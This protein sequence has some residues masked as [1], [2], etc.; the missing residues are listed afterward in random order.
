MIGGTTLGDV[1]RA[2]GCNKST[3]SR[4]LRGLSGVQSATAQKIRTVARELGYQPD[5]IQ[6]NAAAHRWRHSGRLASYSVAFL[7]SEISDQV[8]APKAWQRRLRE[9]AGAAQQRLEAAGCYFEIVNICDYRSASSL[10]RVLQNRG[11]RGVIVPPLPQEARRFMESFDWESFA[12]VALKTGWALPPCHS[13]DVDEWLGIHGAW[14]ELRLRG[15]SRI[16]LAPARHE[17]RALDDF[18]R[19]GA[20]AALSE[21]GMTGESLP[22]Y[23]GL[24]EDRE[25]FLRWLQ[26]VE[27][28][29]VIGFCNPMLDW[30]RS[31]RAGSRHEIGFASLHVN[32]CTSISGMVPDNAGI[33][34]AAVD[35]LMTEIR[36]NHWG[37]PGRRQ[38]ILLAPLWNEGLTLRERLPGPSNID[39]GPVFSQIPAAARDREAT[40]KPP[41]SPVRE[42]QGRPAAAVAPPIPAART[43]RG[44]ARR[45]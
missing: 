19:H 30:L 29:A 28:D 3:V 43:W 13:V 5:P 42:E 18:I 39:S 38:R 24:M 14:A 1:A 37:L 27:P 36:N 31:S 26:E 7:S 16:G 8:T 6:A 15:Y 25:S 2:I 12:S 33:A 11:I 45:P 40:S 22:A 20:C 35:F 41:P 21:S 44:G 17:P 32:E 34:H 9:L 23:H 4:A 10:C